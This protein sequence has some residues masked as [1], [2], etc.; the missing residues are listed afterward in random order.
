MNLNKSLKQL[1]LYLIV[2]AIAAI[3]EWICFYLFFEILDI[4]YL[5]AT[6]ISLIIS[7]FANWISGKLIIFKNWERVFAEII[8]IYLTSAVGVI[9]NLILMWLMVDRFG[10]LEMISKM[11]ATCLVFAWNFLIRKLVIYKI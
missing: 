2:G 8:K 10:L 11:I 5:L 4:N 9:L 1:I 6:V 7:T 3:V